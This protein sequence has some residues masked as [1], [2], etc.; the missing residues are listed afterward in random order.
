MVQ[1]AVQ[2]GDLFDYIAHTGCFSENVCRY[3]LKQMLKAVDH[4]HSKSYAHRDLKPENIL[5]DDDFDIKLCDFGFATKDT[6]FLD[7]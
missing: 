1:E 3:F 7:T 2:G 4:M 5:I 6:G